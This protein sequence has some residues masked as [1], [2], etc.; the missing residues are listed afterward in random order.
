[1]VDYCVRH[2]WDNY[3]LAAADINHEIVAILPVHITANK[4]H[5]SFSFKW[6]LNLFNVIQ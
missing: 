6:H 5:V 2:I 3:E 4:T 1:M